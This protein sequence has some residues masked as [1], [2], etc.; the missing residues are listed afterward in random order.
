MELSEP[1]DAYA[2]RVFSTAFFAL[3]WG[4]CE[5]SQHLADVRAGLSP[6]Q[7]SCK[8]LVSMGAGLPTQQT[9][10]YL[11]LWLVFIA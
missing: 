8:R 3:F 1:F 5:L 9:S 2:G 6:R 10:W 11:C 7:Y 4:P